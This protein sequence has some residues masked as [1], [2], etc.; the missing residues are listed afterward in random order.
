MGEL[1]A[2]WPEAKKERWAAGLCVKDRSE[3]CHIVQVL[4]SMA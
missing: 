2:R 1:A 4:H 3:P